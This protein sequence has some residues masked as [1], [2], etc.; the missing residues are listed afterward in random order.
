MC[1]DYKQLNKNT[2]KDKFPIPLIEDLVDELH[3][4]VIFSKLDLRSGYHQI[5]MWEN[6]IEKTTFKTHEGRY[7]FLVMPF[8]LT[9][10]H[11]TFQSLMNEVFRPFLRK[12][13]LVFF[14]DIMIYSPTK[15]IH[16]KHLRIIFDK[17]VAIDPSK[18]F[19]MK[20]W[21]Q[22]QNLKQLR[23]FLGL[24]GHYRRF[25]KSYAI[26]SHPLTALLKNNAF[27]WSIAAQ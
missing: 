12:F 9:N 27:K 25:V 10:A 15:E 3:G 11:S 14:N 1:I 2:I 22:P 24:T 26:I 17:G 13:T 7:G 18:V 19:A 23:G 20:E 8:G 16:M 21:P 6:D 5:R 4:S